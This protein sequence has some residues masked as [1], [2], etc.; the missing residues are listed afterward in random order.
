[1]TGYGLC[2]NL[3]FSSNTGIGLIFISGKSFIACTC[4]HVDCVLIEVGN[5]QQMAW[6]SI[7]IKCALYLWNRDPIIVGLE[8]TKLGAVIL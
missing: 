7:L 6:F 4:L 2:S 5:L 3:S 8:L 1:M